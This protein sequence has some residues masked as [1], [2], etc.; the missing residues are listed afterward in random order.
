MFAQHHEYS[1]FVSSHT[2]PTLTFP[3]Y[4]TQVRFPKTRS[5]FSHHSA[6]D[7][8]APFQLQHLSPFPRRTSFFLLFTYFY[9]LPRNFWIGTNASRQVPSVSPFIYPLPHFPRVVETLLYARHF[10]QSCTGERRVQRCLL[11]SVSRS[12]GRKPPCFFGCKWKLW[13]CP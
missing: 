5:T 3:Y 12:F 9:S 11:C 8:K 13:E 7:S 6:L 1:C 4:F 2:Q 10:M